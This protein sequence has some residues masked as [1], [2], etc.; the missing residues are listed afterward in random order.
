MLP[1]ERFI[2]FA[3]QNKLFEPGTK[4][5][6]AVSG[7]IDSV[8][9]AHL[10]KSAGYQFGIA[11]CNFML[12]GPEADA[13]QEFTRTLA[14]QLGVSF[15]TTNFDTKH[16]AVEHKL[17]TQMAARELRYQWFA[18][19]CQ[20]A[21]YDAVALAH[22]QNDTIETILL[23]LTRGT[24][25]AG[26]HGIM[27]KNGN[28]VRPLLFMGREEIQEIVATERLAFM[29]DSSNASVKY[30][31]N[32]IRHLVVPVLK[33]LNPA[34]EDTFERNLRNFREMEQLLNERVEALRAEVMT[35]HGD[36]VRISIAAVK[37]ISP[38]RLLLFK[39]LQPYGFVEQVVDDLI[40][41]LDKHAGRVFNSNTHTLVVD[42]GTLIIAVIKAADY[43]PVVIN[44]GETS[45]DY[46]AYKLRVLHDDSP[47]II[48]D[49]PLATSVDAELLVYPLTLRSWQPGDYFYPL[50]MKTKQKLSDFFVHQKVPLHQKSEV[51]VLVNANGDIIWL[52]G[53]RPDERY[54]VGKNTKKVTIFELIKL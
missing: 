42:R 5:L 17:S 31:R 52:G 13:E 26:M 27:P 23:N 24:G 3:V 10:L 33:E 1:V 20:T 34:L 11:H 8:L 53:Y 7:G 50:G 25:I 6:A 9:M 35:E 16:Y 15:H 47:L 21:G 39:L 54:K 46:R 44:E 2:D 43:T 49:N 32:K 4:V 40:S 45:V 51:P 12:R 28:L 41:A 30:A 29:E 14:S 19:L 38:Q 37:N 48:K 18:R 36:E 22:H